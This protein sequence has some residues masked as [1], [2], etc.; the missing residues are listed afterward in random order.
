[1]LHQG[2]IN[3][4]AMDRV[5]YGRACAEAVAA[6]AARLGAERVFLMVSGTLNRET[7]AIEAV[8]AALGPRYAGTWDDMPAHTPREQV[9]AAAAAA[10]GVNADLIATVGGGSVTDGA[11]VV[12]ICLKHGITGIDG[13]D[14]Y[15]IVVDADGSRHVPS[16][17]GPEVRQVTVP[18][19]LSGG[20]FNPLGGCTDSRSKVKEGYRHRL[21]VPRAVILDPAITRHTPEWLWLSTG[22]RALDHAV[23]GLCSIKANPYTDGM[24]L[25]ALRLLCR[26]LPG[27][28]SDPD[29]LGARLDCQ[30]GMWMAMSGVVAGVPMGASHGIGH[31]LGGTCDVPHGYTSCIMLPHV[32][33][34]NRAETADSQRRIAEAMGRP[35]TD[36][37][38]VVGEFIAGLGL[39]RRL[40]EVGVG[41][42]RFELVAENSMHDHWL[43]TNPRKIAGAEDVLEILNMAA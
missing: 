26:G 43:H 8:R 41:A 35:G 38:E 11:K 7:D 15:R 18:T 40:A 16:Y 23:E 5:V 34:Y 30:I 20:E 19:T 36:A 10:R 25:H 27:V 32:L 31:V 12:Q 28:K 42:D 33:A 1:M 21:T 2:A 13:L 37:A 39:P 22:V 24:L 3:N 9:V 29:D 17:D 6:E 4:T 14:D